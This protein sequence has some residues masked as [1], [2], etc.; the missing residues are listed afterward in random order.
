MKKADRNECY[1]YLRYGKIKTGC[2]VMTE[3]QCNR[4]GKCGFFETPEEYEER[5][6]DFADRHGTT[7]GY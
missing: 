6:R 4:K 5:Q 2:Q 3:F 7:K 1:W